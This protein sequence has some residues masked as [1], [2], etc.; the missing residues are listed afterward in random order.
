M[1]AMSTSTRPLLAAAI[2]SVL[3]LGT[4][5]EASA[6]NAHDRRAAREAARESR[7]TKEERVQE[8]PAATRKEPGL[9]A[10]S[11]IGAHIN[12]VSAAQQEGDLAA[13]EAAAEAI[14]GNDK[15]N[16]YERAITLRLLADVLL[17]SDVERAK[18]Y[19][20]QVIEL[21]G[22]ANNDHY[23]TML[24]LAQ[25]DLQDDDYAGTLKWL[26][27]LVAETGTDKADVH[28]LRGN[29]LYRLER[30]EDAIAALEPLVK[31]NPEARADWTQLLMA[32]YAES[33]RSAEAA[34]LA[35]QVAARTPDDKRAQL[36]L[37]SVYLQNEDYANAIAVYERLHKAG[38]LTEDREYRNLFAL[39]LNSD[40]H[41]RQA[42]AVI[43]EGLSTGILQPDNATY[44]SL[45]QA[46]Y[47]SEQYE[48][49]IEAYQKAAPLD[50]DGSTYLNLAK[51]LFNEGR[52]AESKAAAQK[53]LDKGL[54]NPEEA[55]KLL[56]R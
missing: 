19:L 43:E 26:D 4:V 20:R 37:A 22:L 1:S 21:D 35:E 42:I 15:A 30:Y 2:A 46:Y 5:S 28:V 16:A 31:G 47:F 56:S 12:K 40:N 11:R 45:A 39:Y 27:R 48:K 14:L 49:A 3:L 51:V 13:A 55:R 29:A 50:D 38:Q 24:V 23:N 52:G 41:E 54:P 44:V 17:E 10:S 7:P 9:A 25:L 8:F 18:D 53:A 6:Q 36:N 32:S 34:Q 33:G